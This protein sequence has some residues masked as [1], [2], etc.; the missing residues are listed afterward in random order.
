MTTP[1]EIATRVFDQFDKNHDSSVD[2]G[3]VRCMLEETFKG[4]NFPVT[5]QDENA[6]LEFMR[7]N[8]DDGMISKEEFVSM[9]QKTF[10]NRRKNY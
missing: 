10:A 2:A 7:N 8:A 1:Q 9:V 3:M 4:L 6:A 5:E